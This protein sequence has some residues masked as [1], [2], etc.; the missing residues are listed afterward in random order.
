MLVARTARPGCERDLEAWVHGVGAAAGAW[1]GH[2]GLTV[3]RGSPP[4]GTRDYT[5]VFRFATVA[6]LQAWEASTDRAEWLRRV[7][8]LVVRTELQRVSGLETW[9]TLPGGAV[10]VPP[11]RWKM[12]VISWA[13][14]FPLIQLLGATLAPLLSPLPGLVRGAL[15]GAAMVTAMTYWFMP[16]ATRLAARW[17]YPAR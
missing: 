13:V 2:L 11:P 15:V 8:P 5:L 9:F 3:L 7:E 14:A 12:A 1:P 6:Q 16:L 10:L 4:A 17:L